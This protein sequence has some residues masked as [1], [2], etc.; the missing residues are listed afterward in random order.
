MTRPTSR[1]PKTQTKHEENRL[2][3]REGVDRERGLVSRTTSCA[4]ALLLR[5]VLGNA[6][7]PG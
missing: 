3:K 7:W 5:F 2:S 1:I 4:A 6:G